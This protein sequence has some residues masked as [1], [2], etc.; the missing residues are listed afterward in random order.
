MTQLLNRTTVKGSKSSAK[1]AGADQLKPREGGYVLTKVVFDDGAA[2]DGPEQNRMHAASISLMSRPG[3]FL[4][5]D[6]RLNVA[7]V[8]SVLL[9]IV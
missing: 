9:P 5:S 7:S 8:D 6:L 4:G 2:G 1:K 3:E